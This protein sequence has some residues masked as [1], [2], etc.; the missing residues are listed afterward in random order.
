MAPVNNDVKYSN[1]DLLLFFES[2][3]VYENY[4]MLYKNNFINYAF[5]LEISINLIIKIVEIKLGLKL[6][7]D[8]SVLNKII[9][10]LINSICDEQN[11]KNY[12]NAI[13]ANKDTS[14]SSQKIILNFITNIVDY[15]VFIK[16]LS[17]AIRELIYYTNNYSIEYNIKIVWEKYFST[18]TFDFTQ[19]FLQSYTLRKYKFD[20]D[21]FTSLIYIYLQYYISSL[22]YEYFSSLLNTFAE[23]LLGVFR[24]VNKKN[25]IVNLDL[26][27]IEII[28]FNELISK[29]D[30]TRYNKSLNIVQKINEQLS[31][32][33][34][35]LINVSYINNT[36]KPL[37]DLQLTL[38]NYYLSYIDY[39]NNLQIFSILDNDYDYVGFIKANNNIL[40]L[41][42]II[43]LII[44]S[45]Y[46][47]YSRYINIVDYILTNCHSYV[48]NGVKI[49]ALDITKNI[50][51][52]FDYLNQNIIP[53]N[54]INNYYKEIQNNSVIDNYNYKINSFIEPYNNFDFFSTPIYNKYINELS[55][56]NENDI[57][58]LFINNTILNIINNY[59]GLIYSIA[60]FENNQ[61][62]YISLVINF[63]ISN[64]NV[65]LSVYKEILGGDSYNIKN[66]YLSTKN[67]LQLFNGTSYEIGDKLVTIFTLIY[68]Q[69]SSTVQNNDI[70]IILFY[71]NCFITW[72]ST[73]CNDYIQSID[74][75]IYDFSNLINRNILRYLELI[76]YKNDYNYS[77]TNDNYSDTNTNTNS[78]NIKI[79]REKNQLIELKE[80]EEFFNGL[81][82]ILF[83]TYTNKEYIDICYNY[84]NLLV[85]NFNYTD[86]KSIINTVDFNISTFNGYPLGASIS[87]ILAETYN[88]QI[89]N[90]Y[91]LNNKLIAWKQF[92]G[93]IVD[94]NDSIIIKYMKSTNEVGPINPTNEFINFIEKINNGLIYN[95][96]IL[97]IFNEIKLLFDDEQIDL[98]TPETYKVFINLYTNLN[99]YPDLA[100]MLG[101]NFNRENES[102]ITNGLTNWIKVF[103]KKTFYIPMLFFF[104]KYNNAIPLIA[105]IYT[106][107]SI[108]VIL[109]NYN[110]FKD[111]YTISN[112][113]GAEVISALNMDFILVE[114]DERKRICEK[115]ID[116]LIETHNQYSQSILINSIINDTYGDLVVITFD[117]GINQIVKELIWNFKFYLND[118]LISNRYKTEINA[119]Y[120]NIYDAILNTRL[121]IDGARRDGV[122][123]L[124][125]N[126]YNAITTNIN[127]YKYH[128]RA[129]ANN[130]Y[131]VYSFALEPEDFQPTGAM[132]LN[133]YQ[134]FTIEII[135]DKKGLVDYLNNINT[136]YG[137][138]KLSININLNTVNYNLVRYQS[139]LSGLLFI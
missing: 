27:V 32:S 43:V 133:P 127:P 58:K 106:N 19:L 71:Y 98:I 9:N 20:I 10:Q 46:I 35:N 22:Q 108:D 76:N 41:Y 72:I 77:S 65:N 73:H 122:L 93:L 29:P 136:L 8:L 139:G 75:L 130:Y 44:C 112:L 88:Y 37:F 97:K 62:S 138:N 79:N 4:N 34:W 7:Y 80:L 49:N 16:K 96:G 45:K 40:I 1:S 92:L 55:F 17:S 5:R 123:S 95:Y 66:I 12:I 85:S 21:D 101:V 51:T 132:N 30:D 63:I 52:Y 89:Y 102:Y 33:T 100:E 13:Y 118:Y 126:N 81:N 117:F 24:Y 119:S 109:N 103:N 61:D 114:R 6:I 26:N 134:V 116:N 105:G 104:Q 86:K 115:Q 129:I 84:F 28:I 135:M 59:G 74:K 18:I 121:Y 31:N 60:M 124:S 2:I 23:Y 36:D 50:A 125:A 47:T 69:I 42:R 128:S 68:S 137:L 99:K 64:I 15:N 48:L 107:F 87:K 70:I 38:Y 14:S 11:I 67:I 25:E 110:I 113:T 3:I 82:L 131:N 111:T 90:E 120:Y 78:N 91:I 83:N 56:T 54:I 53:T 94:F 39:I 57:G